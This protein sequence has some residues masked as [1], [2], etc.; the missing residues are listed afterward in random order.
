[1]E[2][3]PGLLQW[4]L[5]TLQSPASSVSRQGGAQGLAEV[6]AV[7]PP[8]IYRNVLPHVIANSTGGKPEAREGHLA[9]FAYLPKTSPRQFE[10][11]VADVLPCVLEGFSD[12]ADGVRDTALKVS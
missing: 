4:L 2:S 3:F 9:L 1:M 10:F 7:I 5:D 11:Y 12:E 6:L 8:E